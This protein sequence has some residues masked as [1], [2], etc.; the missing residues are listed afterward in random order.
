VFKRSTVSLDVSQ[1]R[2]KYQ[3]FRDIK[4]YNDTPAGGSY[5]AGLEPL[6]NFT[7]TIYQGYLS[8]FF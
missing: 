6:Y 5:P 1:I 8:V 3:D 4:D 7:A 2:F